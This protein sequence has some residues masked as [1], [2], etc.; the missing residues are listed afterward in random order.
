MRMNFFFGNI[1]WGILLVLWGASLILK[2]FNIHMPLAK[3]FIAV[4][5]IMFGIK[6]LIG[7]NSKS[8]TR[9]HSGRRNYYR[10][11]RSGEYTMVF[12]SGTIDLRDINEN[13]PNMEITVV[14]GNCTVILPAHLSFDIEPTSVFGATILPDKSHYGF[15]E[16][17]YQNNGVSQSMIHIESTSVFGRLEYVFENVET[18]QADTTSTE[19]RF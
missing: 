4:V 6:L 18:V 14:F 19:T 5:I 2:T 3:I 1:F 11:N 9:D 13:N 16:S 15:G 7:S 8:L 17:H 12:S 10:S